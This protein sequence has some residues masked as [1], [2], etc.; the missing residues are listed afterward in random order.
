[1]SRKQGKAPASFMERE[2]R[3]HHVSQLQQYPSECVSQLLQ[4]P[5]WHVNLQ[6]Q[7]LLLQLCLSAAPP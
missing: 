6:L 3:E 5:S 1:M 4:Y 2:L 7:A